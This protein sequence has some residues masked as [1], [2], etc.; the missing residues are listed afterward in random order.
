MIKS[1]ENKI[2]ASNDSKTVAT[3]STAIC[4][5]QLS[6]FLTKKMK[7][8]WLACARFDVWAVRKRERLSDSCCSTRAIAAWN[9]TDKYDVRAKVYS[10]ARPSSVHLLHDIQRKMLNWTG[11]KCPYLLINVYYYTSFNSVTLCPEE[12]RARKNTN[13]SRVLP[14]KTHVKYFWK[15]FK[16][17]A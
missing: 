16:V 13:C 12:W 2:S 6:C 14:R 8:K 4:E 5:S 3:T 10:V 17:R 7:K 9:R 1:I 11:K 15:M